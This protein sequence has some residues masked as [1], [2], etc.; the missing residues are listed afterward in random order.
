MMNRFR[1]WPIRAQLTILIALLAI[2]SISLIVYS[3][4]AERHEAIAGAKTE[5]LKFVNDVAGQHKAI[6]AGVEQLAT[7]LALLPQLQ[8]RNP[9]AATALFSELLKKNPQ[10]ANI[11]SS[12]THPVLSGHRQ[13]PSRGRCRL[14]TESFF[15]RQPVPGC[16]L[17]VNTS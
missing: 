5:C 14:L 2:P 1:S 13:S 7:A 12:A 15:K 3:G 9:A 8:S 10:Y 11:P 16:F 6:V 4:I 17:P